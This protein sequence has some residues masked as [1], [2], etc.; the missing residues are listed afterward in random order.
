MKKEISELITSI[1]DENESY[2]ALLAEMVQLREDQNKSQRELAEMT[3]L[4][5]SAIARLES[6]ASSGT[7]NAATILKYLNALG[8]E[9]T[10]RPKRE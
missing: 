10:I 3:G 1:S 9:L 2:L 5:Q 4:K 7:P 8:Y 6:P